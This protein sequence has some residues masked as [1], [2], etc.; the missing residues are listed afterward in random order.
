MQLSYLGLT[1]VLG[2]LTGD[3]FDIQDE[4]GDFEAPLYSSLELT[5]QI[6]QFLE[7]LTPT[8]LTQSFWISFT[9]YQLSNAM[10]LLIRCLLACRRIGHHSLLAKSYDLLQRFTIILKEHHRPPHCWDL[11]ERALAKLLSL[12]PSVSRTSPTNTITPSLSLTLSLY[13]FGR[14]LPRGWAV[15]ERAVGADLGSDASVSDGRSAHLF[16]PQQRSPPEP[17]SA[18]ST[19]NVGLGCPHPSTAAKQPPA[20]S[21]EIVA[22]DLVQRSAGTQATFLS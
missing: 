18:P 2:R 1:I 10:S 14:S 12:M 20:L 15:L 9:P 3:L 13:F 17:S 11:A 8:D 5:D 16:H 4:E 19:L 6:V 22:L 21:P 7:R